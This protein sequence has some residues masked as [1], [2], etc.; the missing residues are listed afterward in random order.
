MQ[1]SNFFE[2]TEIVS[3]ELERIYYQIDF[4]LNSFRK[5]ISSFN[6]FGVNIW[7]I[8]L[9][10]LKEILSQEETR[11][12]IQDIQW[13]DNL[14]IINF[15]HDERCYDFEYSAMKKKMNQFSNL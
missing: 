15:V 2:K 1:A 8:N 6:G 14:L 5:N 11:I 7:N 3:G 13:K 10:E 9:V 4:I 12:D